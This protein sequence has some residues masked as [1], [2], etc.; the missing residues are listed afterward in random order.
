MK[1]QFFIDSNKA[2]ILSRF[3]SSRGISLSGYVRNVMNSHIDN[4]LNIELSLFSK[5]ESINRRSINSEQRLMLIT[6]ILLKYIS[7]VLAFNAN[8]IEPELWPAA[9][10]IGERKLDELLA[11]SRGDWE[12][13]KVFSSKLA[14]ILL[15]I[16]EQLNYSE[17]EKVR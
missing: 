17:E 11:E 2:Q 14:H 12:T 3:A 16:N 9:K 13:G 6:D 1:I 5:L 4:E 8:S 10:R 15:K 7:Y